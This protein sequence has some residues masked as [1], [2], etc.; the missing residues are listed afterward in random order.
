MDTAV[1]NLQER[2]MMEAKA[3][4]QVNPGESLHVH[5]LWEST[6]WVNHE[7]RRYFIPI[8]RNGSTCF[9][10]NIAEQYNYKLEK[11]DKD[12]GYIGYVYL[13]NPD[14]R[15]EGQLE[16][17]IINSE[18]G[19]VEECLRRMQI[20]IESVPK[21]YYKTTGYPFDVHYKPQVN[22]LEGY[23]IKY[24]LDLDNLKHVGDSH[25]DSVTDSMKAAILLPAG[26]NYR[27]PK[28]GNLTLKPHQKQIIKQVYEK[29]YIL[30]KEKI[31]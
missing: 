18:R 20:P 11:L 31:K 14:L 1:L 13:R 19:T 22:F 7:H 30:F 24:Y 21:K 25:I 6:V 16:V 28:I 8:W 3:V 15:I 27:N 23:D 12:A 5:G 2:K 9:M 26:I 4:K 29:D 10:Y 17:A